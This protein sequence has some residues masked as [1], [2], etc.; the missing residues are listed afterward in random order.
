M[1]TLKDISNMLQSSSILKSRETKK[2]YVNCQ[3]AFI[4]FRFNIT[5]FFLIMRVKSKTKQKNITEVKQHAVICISTN[6]K[7]LT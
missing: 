3:F 7:G 5:F 2:I 1:T 4:N 6:H